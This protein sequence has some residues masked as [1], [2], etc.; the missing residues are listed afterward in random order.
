MKRLITILLL[1]HVFGICLAQYQVN[2]LSSTA[3]SVTL[4]STGYEKKAKK[5]IPA[6]ELSAIKVLLFQGVDNAVY[7][8]ALVPMTEKDALKK[9]PKYFNNLFDGGYRNFIQ[10]SVVAQG[11]HKDLAKRKNMVLD[12]TV[13]IKA[14]REDLERNGIIRKF[15]L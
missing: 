15:G 7:S 12:V 5:A 3:T 9:H 8:H 11:M 4:R 6:A 14:L 10:S 1:S 2:Y 13:N